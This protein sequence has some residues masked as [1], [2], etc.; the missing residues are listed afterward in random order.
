MSK[1]WLMRA[2]YVFLV[3]VL[4]VSVLVDSNGRIIGLSESLSAIL[5][6]TAFAGALFVAGIL[7]YKSG[8]WTRA[9]AILEVILYVLLL[10]PAV[11]PYI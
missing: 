1:R 8:G 4:A 2:N 3:A 7:L 9:L 11:L 10:L 6:M 5:A